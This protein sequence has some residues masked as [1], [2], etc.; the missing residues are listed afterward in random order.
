ML[1]PGRQQSTVA[2]N[3]LADQRKVEVVLTIASTL[4]LVG[5]ALIG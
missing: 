3:L 1:Y 5:T 4:A 2:P